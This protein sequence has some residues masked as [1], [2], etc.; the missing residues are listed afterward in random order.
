MDDQKTE[1]KRLSLE[2]SELQSLVGHTCDHCRDR[3]LDALQKMLDRYER[4]RLERL[5]QESFEQQEA[6][7]IRR[8]F[9]AGD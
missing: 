6:E 8:E 4:D 2:V 1:G 7:R 9:Q 5:A 3:V